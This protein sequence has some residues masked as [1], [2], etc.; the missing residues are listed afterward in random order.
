MENNKKE[1]LS[2]TNEGSD[3]PLLIVVAGK[4]IPRERI[5]YYWRETHKVFPYIRITNPFK[6]KREFPFVRRWL[7]SSWWSWKT[8]DCIAVELDNGKIIR[9]FYEDGYYASCTNCELGMAEFARNYY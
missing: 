6:W 1:N 7:I 4:R 5:I 9:Q 3:K 8:L 2:A